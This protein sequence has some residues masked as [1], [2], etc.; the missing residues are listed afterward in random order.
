MLVG[1]IPVS[2]W[3]LHKRGPS[4]PP[5]S[6]ANKP[7]SRWVLSKARPAKKAEVAVCSLQFMYGRRHYVGET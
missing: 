4:F 6:V 3:L 5:P 7:G 2:G 1:G